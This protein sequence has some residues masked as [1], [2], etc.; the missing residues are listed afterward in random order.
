MFG[1]APAISLFGVLGN[2]FSIV[3]LARQGLRR[4]SNILLVS[5]A[6][7]DITFLV[8]FNGVP[9]IIYE[10]VWNH[11]YVGYSLLETD[12]LFVAFSAFMF[13]DYSFGLMGLTLPMLI[14]VERLVV[15]FFPLNFRRIITPARTW[16][17]VAGLALYWISIFLY[18]SFWQEIRYEFDTTKNVSIGIIRKSAF[19]EQHLDVVAA[20]EDLLIYTSM[21]IP[22]VFTVVGCVVISVKI[23][24]TSLK[25]Q[26]MTTKL[27]TGSRTTRTL[28]AVC[29]VYCVTAAVV[30]LPLYI[31]QYASYSLTDES[32]SNIG[33]IFYQ[34][35]NTVGCINSSS[36]FVVYVALNKNFR[37]TYVEIFR[38]R[39]KQKK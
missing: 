26:K 17:A 10:A 6:F 7:C 36:N 35:V 33:K 34:L 11:E 21:I 22:P 16:A 29:A 27:K 13:L 39:K 9:K 19:F 3:V 2:I 18:S 14:T 25:R 20:F 4:C 31:P 24:M 8:S 28:L 38:C 1:V 37:A 5:L 30:S 15:I 23:K 12:I 32:P